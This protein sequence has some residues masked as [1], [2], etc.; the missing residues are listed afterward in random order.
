MVTI[1]LNWG[2]LGMRMG[3][4]LRLLCLMETVHQNQFRC[5]QRLEFPEVNF[6]GKSQ[7]QIYC[8]FD[9]VFR[10]ELVCCVQLRQMT[11]WR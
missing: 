4:I 1:A 3:P 10:W 8:Y 7:M 9:F 6:E 11:R 2:A 5:Q